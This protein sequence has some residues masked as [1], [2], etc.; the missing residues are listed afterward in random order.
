M[1]RHL[2]RLL[3]ILILAFPAQS[4]WALSD[5]DSDIITDVSEDSSDKKE[6]NRGHRT[7]PRHFTCIIS[8]TNGITI[9]NFNNVHFRAYELIDADTEECVA[10]FTNESGFIDYI[11]SGITGEFIIRLQTGDLWLAGYISI[12]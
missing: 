2:F 6:Y 11:Y 3:L 1:C 12:P 7:I 10:S 4:A 9:E 8:R 5:D